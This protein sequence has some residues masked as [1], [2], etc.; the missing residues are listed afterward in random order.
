MADP[1]VVVIGAG[2]AGLSA[3]AMLA[4]HGV[5]V[6]VLDARPRLGGRATAFPDLETGE[7]VDNG[8]HVMFGCYRETLAFLGRIGA[9]QNVRVQRALEV[10][11]IDVE[12]RRSVLR[13][14]RLPAPLHLL[15]GVLTW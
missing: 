7:L 3:A 4:D 10:P 12:G 8:Q 11:F 13:C 2:F 6:T 5:A 14:P 1:H 9:E 15:A